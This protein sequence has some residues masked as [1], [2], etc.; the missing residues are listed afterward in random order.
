MPS[1]P[2]FIPTHAPCDLTATLVDSGQAFGWE[3]DPEG[4]IRGVIGMRACKLRCGAGGIQWHSSSGENARG[5]LRHFLR[6]DEDWPA[7]IKTFPEDEYLA[8]AVQFAPGLR[9]VRQDPWECLASFLISPL[10]QIPQIKLV[11]SS[12]RRELGRAIAFDG[13]THHSFPAPAQIAQ[14]GEAG[15]RAHRMGFRAR[16]LLGTAEQIASGG[17]D[18]KKI[19]T[20]DDVRAREELCK[21]RGVGP[22]IADCV[23]LFAYGRAGAI[24][25][26]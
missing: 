1:S 17:V 8:R 19:E 22:K 9:L 14:A 26:S 7:I 20:M 5:D 21:L 11:L 25:H 18:L 3:Q 10:K 24:P 2:H 13:R 12:L 4:W 16:N 6:V 15:L 23:L